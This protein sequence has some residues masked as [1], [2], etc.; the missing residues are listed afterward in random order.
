MIF[1]SPPTCEICKEAEP[2]KKPNGKYKQRCKRCTA[3]YDS[4]GV[5][6]VIYCAF[7][8]YARGKKELIF[9]TADGRVQRAPVGFG[10][11][12]GQPVSMLKNEMKVQAF[13]LKSVDPPLYQ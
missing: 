4:A 13:T 8:R 6:F 2:E 1:Q 10:I 11:L 5:A 9:W 3:R 7:W 12:Q